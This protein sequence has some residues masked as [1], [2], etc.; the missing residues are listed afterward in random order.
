MP[1]DT[2]IYAQYAP[3]P[4]S[5]TDYLAEMDDQE[6]RKQTL[7]QNRLALM[8][9][10]GKLDDDMRTRQEMGVVRNALT[11]LASTATDDDRITALRS[12]G[13]LTGFNQAAALAKQ[14]AESRRQKLDADKA[15]FDLA[16]GRF[17]TYRRTLGVLAD[18]PNL[19]KPMALQAAQDLVRQG[20][21]DQ[22]MFD[23]G[24]A[25]LSDDPAQLRLQLQQGLASQASP[26][27]IL[28]AFGP[29]PTV[30][31]GRVVDLNPRSPTYGKTTVQRQPNMAQDLLIPGA[32]GQ[33]VP[34]QQLIDTRTRLAQA[35]ATTVSYGA[36]V[37]VELPDGTRGLVQPGNRPDAPAKLLTM[38]GTDTPLKPAK[39]GDLNEGQSKAV[40]FAARMISSDSIIDELAK[41][42]RVVQTP[43]SA[44]TG[45]VGSVVNALSPEDNQRLD[46]AKRNFI[47]AVLRRE[48]GAVIGP[49]E[50]ASFDRLYFAQPGETDAVVKQKANARR[51]AIASMRAEVPG[52][53][54]TRI[55]DI[56]NPGKR[57]EEPV[58]DPATAA[59]SRKDYDAMIKS[60]KVRRW[61]PQTNQ[62]EEF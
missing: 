5:V 27:Q 31:D 51:I 55:D 47:N 32:N 29:K 28:T 46:Q 38:P 6:Q 23:S 22:Q 7:Q 8:M 19:T 61:N 25:T 42:G 45:V 9:N 59:Q 35:G 57:K 36:P 34:N 48:S 54:Q 50:F 58:I 18:T 26:E 20:I 10:Q 33:M 49:E 12:T 3:K 11:R 52:S 37:E 21:I 17:D 24:A 62:L 2:S 15:A 16:K 30:V 40:G 60:G 53:A 13:T 44:G 14:L 56:V 41:K 1:I 39:Q 4:R 43:G